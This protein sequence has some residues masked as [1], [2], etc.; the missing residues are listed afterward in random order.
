V[1]RI[2]LVAALAALVV[3]GCASA[4]RDGRTGFQ[5]VRVL[6]GLDSPTQVT[7]P[8]GSHGVL[9]VVEQPGVIRVAVDG[10]LRAQPFLDIRSR[11]L[12]GGE[13]GLLGLAFAPDYAKSRLFVVDYTDRDGNTQV[14]RYRSNGVRAIPASARRLLFVRQPATNHNGGQVAFGPDGKLYV[15]MGDGGGSPGNRSQSTGTLLGKILRLEIA[16][17]APRPA[18]V[19]LGLRN[20]WRFSFDRTGGDLWIGDVGQSTTEEVDHLTWPLRRLVNLGWPVYE[21]HDAY[22][23][24]SLGPGTL[25]W[26]V[27]EYSHAQ[28]CSIVGGFV[29]RGRAVPSLAG[30][31]VYG[32]YCSGTVWS[33]K[34]GRAGAVVRKEPFAIRALTSFGEDGSGELWAVGGGNL[35]RLTGRG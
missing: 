1:Q 27:A 35:Y 28:G 7:A 26:P 31:Y 25:T 33:L 20:P 9:Y 23:E 8:P 13:Q 17:P 15:G 24:G 2:V 11:V 29:Y 34:L 21:A 6:S 19:V 22:Q 14:V 4:Q 32:D 10:K 18:I 5:P 12:S 16:R 30:R 3:V